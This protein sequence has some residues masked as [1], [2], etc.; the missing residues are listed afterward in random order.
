[1]K[2]VL[3][4]GASGFIGYRVGIAFHKRGY[5]VI[6]W[7]RSENR[8]LFPIVK[9]DLAD[10]NEVVAQLS[11]F[12]PDVVIHC[13]GAADVGKSVKDPTTDYYGNVTTTHNLLFSLHKTGMEKSRIVF[14]SSAGVYGNPVSLPIVEDMPLNPLSPYAVHKVMCEDLCKYFASNYGMNV[15]VARIFSAYGAGLRK[16]IFWDM[17][18]KM[19]HTGRLDMFG[20]GNESRDY[21]HVD[22]VVQSLYLLATVDSD[23][24]IFNVANGEEVT[25]RE[26]TEMF[27]EACG[28]G[29]E[30][31]CFNGVVREG[32]PLNWRADISKIKQLGY[33]KTV[34]MRMG[35]KGY[36]VWVEKQSCK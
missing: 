9:V 24:V 35:L 36:A 13:A 22:D 19:I 20:T 5:E 1:M 16:Q 7:D 11:L 4:T 12:N 31:I 3:V 2:K 17:Y 27:A 29:N 18:Q 14:L 21:I 6:G 25:I 33:K 30:I 23:H 32:D 8:S 28:A 34:D 26:A 10:E 15:K